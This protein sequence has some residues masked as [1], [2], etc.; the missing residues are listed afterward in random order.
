MPLPGL[1]LLGSIQ[2]TDITSQNMANPVQVLIY[3]L[4]T[5][6]YEDVLLCHSRLPRYLKPP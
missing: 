3:M 2:Y 1:P 5:F 6:S 4:N